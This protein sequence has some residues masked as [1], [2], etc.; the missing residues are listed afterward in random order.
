MNEFDLELEK[1]IAMFADSDKYMDDYREALASIAQC[2]KTGVN[3]GLMMAFESR[4]YEDQKPLEL[5]VSAFTTNYSMSNVEYAI[6][7]FKDRAL[8]AFGKAKDAAQKAIR[9]LYDLMLKVLKTFKKEKTKTDKNIER[10]REETLR[11]LNEYAAKSDLNYWVTSSNANGGSLIAIMQRMVDDI[12][13]IRVKSELVNAGLLE[14]TGKSIGYDIGVGN[15]DVTDLDTKINAAKGHIKDL[16]WVTGKNAYD[17]NT[18]LLSIFVDKSLSDGRG[19]S[20]SP[21]RMLN[22]LLSKTASSNDIDKKDIE[23]YDHIAIIE[24]ANKSDEVREKLDDKAK[25]A[26]E[27]VTANDEYKEVKRSFNE[28][29]DLASEYNGIDEYI[30]HLDVLTRNYEKARQFNLSNLMPALQAANTIVN[31]LS[32]LKDIVEDYSPEVNQA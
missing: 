12:E 16:G 7:G 19:L 3:Q 1:A 25:E 5:P 24:N 29:K 28:A 2:K 26:K 10:T 31:T 11:L 20:G 8:K 14:L 27:A 4:A 32:P 22:D 17:D 18:P 6:E 23:G 15:M 13:N 21:Y 30:N 9:Y